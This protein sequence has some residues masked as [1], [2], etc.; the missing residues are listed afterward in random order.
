MGSSSCQENV[1]VK[2]YLKDWYARLGH[3]NMQ[4][5]R[6]VVSIFQWPCSSDFNKT[7][8]SYLSCYQGKLSKVSLPPIEHKTTSPLQLKH[9]DLWGPSP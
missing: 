8:F 5:I 1:V 4:T 7:S 3:N 9:N 2:I 6:R